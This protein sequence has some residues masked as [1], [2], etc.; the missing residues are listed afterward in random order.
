MTRVGEHSN[1]LDGVTVMFTSRALHLIILTPSHQATWPV[2]LG[3]F[4]CVACSALGG[5]KVLAA[6]QHAPVKAAADMLSFTRRRTDRCVY[7]STPTDTQRA[8]LRAPVECQHVLVCLR[9]VHQV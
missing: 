5:C 3:G 2:S 6:A 1:N 8:S 7:S 4:P 9:W